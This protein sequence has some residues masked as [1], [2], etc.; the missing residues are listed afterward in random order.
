[1]KSMF[2]SSDRVRR[3]LVWTAPI[4]VVGVVVAGVA[5]STGTASGESPTLPFRTP[6]QLIAEVS[7]ATSAFSGTVTETA[8]LGIPT[9]PGGHSSASLS[10]QTFLSGSHTIRVW[11]DGVDKQRLALIGEL[12]EADVVHDG[13]DIWTYTSDTNTVTHNT[14]PGRG[15]ESD[16][17]S[18]ASTG[19]G[20]S[21]AT[22][23]TP[24]SVATRLLKEVTPSTA[25]SVGAT[26]R[27]AGRNAYTLVLRPRDA[28]STISKITIA[29][30]AT[31]H[32]PLQVQV[33]GAG[34]SP[35][36]STGFTKIDYASPGA[37]TFAFTPPA[38]ATTARL[39]PGVS[40][41]TGPATPSGPA[42][43]SAPKVIGSGWTSIVELAGGDTSLVRGSTLQD[44]ATPVGSSGARL[45]HTAVLNAVIL[46]DG[47]AFVGAVSPALLEHVAATTAH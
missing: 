34:H 7:G 21:P 45:L 22:G 47:R 17:T 44:L 37:S 35:A 10:W 15:A 12:S 29:I 36:F 20:S 41:S 2:V 27:I 33:F 23:I 9:L 4:I 28:N 25:V 39:T 38:G 5:W 43:S 42:S 1:M 6:A 24:T 26:Q 31:K 18:G 16:A 3:R 11:A 32:L 40:P 46:P 30:D 13:R 14:L 19:T 8:S